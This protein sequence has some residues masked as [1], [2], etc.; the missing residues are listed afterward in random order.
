MVVQGPV[1]IRS[2]RAPGWSLMTPSDPSVHFVAIPLMARSGVY[3]TVFDLVGD[4]RSRGMNWSAT[5][6]LRPNAPGM[7]RVH[8]A[9]SESVVEERGVGV[10][11][12]IRRLLEESS[13]GAQAN[14]VVTL[15]SQSD[16][17]MSMHAKKRDGQK[18]VAYV[19][20]LPWPD[21]GEQNYLRRQLLR[22]VETFALR[23]ADAVWTTTPVLA[24]QVDSAALTQIVPAGVRPL[25]RTNYGTKPSAPVVWAGRLD[26]DKR[27]HLFVDAVRHANVRA[28][29]WG[30]GPLQESV[31]QACSGQVSYDGWVDT[32]KAW[33]D[34]SVF[35]GTSSR[36]AFGRSAVEAALAGVPLI[37]GSE[38]GAAEFL[39]TDPE[40]SRL[41]VVGSTDP[42]EWARVITY[43][44]SDDRLRHR[45]SDHVHENALNLTIGASVSAIRGNI[46][47]LFGPSKVGTS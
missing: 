22:Q 10:V 43:V 38:Y 12:R 28:R 18:W 47:K 2:S 45:I 37:I 7:R 6:G 41:C 19:R 1:S 26:I 3:N 5:V 42:R 24:R 20:G 39:F 35:V 9:V 36:E 32:R 13:S 4:A 21:K 34:V 11:T 29:I 31:Q 40:L 17:A 8:S 16:V 44:L 23:R 30:D 25:P 33:E 46:R 27:P 15:I 14:C